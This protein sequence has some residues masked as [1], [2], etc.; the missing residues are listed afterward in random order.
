MRS[1]PMLKSEQFANQSGHIILSML[2]RHFACMALFACSV[3]AQI[4]DAPP[5]TVA[6]IPVNYTESLAGT[7]T[8]PNPLVLANGKP[9]KDAKM[10]T[11]KR[12]PEIV[13]LFEENQFGRSPGRPA[14]MSF[15]VFDKG[16]PAFDGKA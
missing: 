8:L 16:T 10:W 15:E 1:A 14:D 3:S 5:D 7:Y 6:G 9:V 11:E 4:A 2:F 12:R 13:K